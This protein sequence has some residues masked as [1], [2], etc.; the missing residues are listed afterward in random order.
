MFF[1]HVSVATQGVTSVELRWFLPVLERQP[2]FAGQPGAHGLN[3]RDGH[4][5]QQL[6]QMRAALLA[7]NSC[8]NR[9]SPSGSDLA[10]HQGPVVRFYVRARR[11]RVLVAYRYQ[12]LNDKLF[13]ERHADVHFVYWVAGGD[14]AAVRIVERI[15]FYID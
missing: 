1:D 9:F 3:R 10:A 4:V 5:V 8:R 15:R 13:I 7:S 2:V 12:I 6:C 11:K 14:H